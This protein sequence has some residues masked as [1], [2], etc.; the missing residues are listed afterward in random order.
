MH[1]E[2]PK[3]LDSSWVRLQESSE[4]RKKPHSSSMP[5]CGYF[6]NLSISSYFLRWHYP[7][8]VQGYFLSIGIITSAPLNQILL[9][10][11]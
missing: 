6:N 4:R 1:E 9:F 3:V 2:S 11:F 8:Q 7:D 10:A 5:E